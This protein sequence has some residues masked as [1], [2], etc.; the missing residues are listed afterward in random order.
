MEIVNNNDNSNVNMSEM[1]VNQVN[2]NAPS[3]S[4][5]LS[6][7]STMMSS[8]RVNVK[9]L[10]AK[11]LSRCLP[12]FQNILSE[13][14]EMV[15]YTQLQQQQNPDEWKEIL[16]NKD[17]SSTMF[18][19]SSLS[20][21]V[22]LVDSSESSVGDLF[23]TRMS[24]IID[25]IA[26]NNIFNKRRSKK[27]KKRRLL[28]CVPKYLRAIWQNCEDIFCQAPGPGQHEVRSPTIDLSKVNI[29]AIANLP[30]PKSFPIHGCSQDPEFYNSR[31]WIM[32]NPFGWKYGYMTQLGPVSVSSQPIHGY[33]FDVQAQDWVLHASYKQEKEREKA[34]SE[35]R[36][37]F[38]K[39]RKIKGK[40][41]THQKK[42]ING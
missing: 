32:A 13:M 35:S 10:D 39:Q 16:S 11:E 8:C 31:E 15:A 23:V 2:I 29:R 34:K 1:P 20:S 5:I 19:S 41:H 26:P 36:V 33:V 30:R 38:F 17:V 21:D 22:S 24:G 6:T 27:M 4:Q 37:Q 12:Y 9:L 18:S 40:Q 7:L 28:Q 42:R 3:T 14:N 25:Y